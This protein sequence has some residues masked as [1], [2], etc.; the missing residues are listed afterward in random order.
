MITRF[1]NK[2]EKFV[3]RYTSVHTVLHESNRLRCYFAFVIT[4][5]RR[6]SRQY[7]VCIHSYRNYKLTR[8]ILQATRVYENEIQISIDGNYSVYRNA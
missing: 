6:L 5:D 8:Q 3:T 7:Q 1:A 4:D 2:G